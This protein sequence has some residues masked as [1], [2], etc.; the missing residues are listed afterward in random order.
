[1][2]RIKSSIV[3]ILAFL[4]IIISPKAFAVEQ[5]LDVMLPSS[6]FLDVPDNY[7]AYTEISEL[8]HKGILK[9]YPN[10]KFR[11]EAISQEK[12]LQQP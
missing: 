1:M 5:I 9:G 8:H 7:W 6:S 2:G 12:N 4:A 10:Q 11:P 3:I